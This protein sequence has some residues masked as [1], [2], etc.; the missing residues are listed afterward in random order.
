M[1]KQKQQQK[2]YSLRKSCVNIEMGGR[3]L[4]RPRSMCQLL[5]RINVAFCR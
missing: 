4:N 1:Q 2:Q 3:K 5:D